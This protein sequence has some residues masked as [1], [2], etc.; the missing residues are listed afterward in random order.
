MSGTIFDLVEREPRPGQQGF[1]DLAENAPTPQSKSFLEKTKKYAKEYGKTALKGTAEGLYQL[2]RVMGPTGLPEH[3][4]LTSELNR[5]LPTEDEQ[6]GQRAL[7]RGLKEAPT[8]LAFPGAATISNLPRPVIAA[9][10]GEGAKDLGAPEWAQTA[11]EITTYIGPDLTKKLLAKGKNK[12]LIEAGK[13][14]GLTD[15]QLTP[16]LQNEFKQK[17]L[18]KLV[19][20]RGGTQKALKETREGLGKAYDTLKNSKAATSGLNEASERLLQKNI[21]KFLVD[22]PSSVRSKILQDYKD[23]FAAPVTGKS[24]MNFYSKV[25]HAI[26]DNSK[27][28]SLIKG[29]I[30]KAVHALSPE[31][32]KDFDLVNN[33]YSKYSNIASRLKPTL[34]S[35]IISAAETLGIFGSVAMGHYPSLIGLLGEQAAKKVAQQML[36]NPHFQQLGRKMVVALNQNKYGL[37]KKIM[38]DYIKEVKKTSPESAKKLED[39]SEEELK[40]FFS[41]LEK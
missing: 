2:G 29:P 6:F 19:P 21:D 32:G 8:A 14:L 39:A 18:S 25:N 24:L 9:F 7:R 37:A 4:E 33:L 1:F 11:L 27:Q 36:I 20:K 17:W 28:L 16:L 23:L 35:D 30:R 34:A 26:G 5:L 22:M 31:L 13:A 38:E 15:E 10:V 40:H 3:K 12:E 41:S